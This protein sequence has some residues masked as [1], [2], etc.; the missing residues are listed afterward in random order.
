MRLT[1][2]GRVRQVDRT[3]ILPLRISSDSLATAAQTNSGKLLLI[4]RQ[5]VTVTVKNRANIACHGDAGMLSSGEPVG[6]GPERA[7]D[8]VIPL[9]I[10][11]THPDL[12]D[13]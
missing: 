1:I 9:R 8:A 11:E 4:I 5:S 3:A 7:D 2:T 12:Q 13:V 6:S 10:A